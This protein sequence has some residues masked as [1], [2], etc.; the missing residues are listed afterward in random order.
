VLVGPVALA[1]QLM[2]LV[3]PIQY[4]HQLLLL[5]AV[6]VEH[7]QEMLLRPVVLVVV[8]VMA[9][10]V[11]DQVLVGRDTLVGLILMALLPMVLVLEEGLVLLVELL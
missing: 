11:L 6:L 8:A 2:L 10:Q 3:V 1:I 5:V 9:L 7:T 4:F